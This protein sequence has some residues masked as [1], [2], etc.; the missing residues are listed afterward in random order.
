VTVVASGTGVRLTVHVRP[1][2]AATAI[3]KPHGD[4]IGVRLAARPVDG[5]ANRELVEFLSRQLGVPRRAVTL[6]AGET[7]RRKI[8]QVAGIDAATARKRLT[9]N[10]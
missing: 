4:A 3:T 2:A 9:T 8:V 6:V 5:K 10:D 7:S 1:G